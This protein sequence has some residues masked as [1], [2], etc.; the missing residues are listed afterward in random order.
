MPRG[1]ANRLPRSRQWSA[2]SPPSAR[3]C[4]P[5]VQRMLVMVAPVRGVTNNHPPTQ[6]AT[7]WATFGRGSCM[8]VA[9]TY[10]SYIG[11]CTTYDGSPSTLCEGQGAI[12]RDRF[13]FRYACVWVLQR[14]RYFFVSSAANRSSEAAAAFAIMV[15]CFCKVEG[16]VIRQLCFSAQ[17][18]V[19]PCEARC[20]H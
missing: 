6:P 4:R 13:C 20:D 1:P 19:R 12:R 18:D 16:V 2:M 3:A 11:A 7:S 14:S 17:A 9:V 15:R 8:L 5:G 10:A